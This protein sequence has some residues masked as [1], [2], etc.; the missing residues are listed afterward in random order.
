VRACGSADDGNKPLAPMN[1][2]ARTAL[3]PDAAAAADGRSGN[4]MDA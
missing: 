3:S 4:A 1:D 2:D